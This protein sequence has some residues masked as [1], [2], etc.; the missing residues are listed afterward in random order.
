MALRRIES[1][2]TI[3]GGRIVHAAAE[4]SRYDPPLPPPSPDWPP[5]GRYGGYTNGA[6]VAPHRTPVMGADGRLWEGDC[7]GFSPGGGSC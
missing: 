7:G 6:P 4:F 3:C 2:L 5:V 1:V